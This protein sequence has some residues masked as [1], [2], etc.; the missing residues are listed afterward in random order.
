[1]GSPL[2]QIFIIFPFPSHSAVLVVLCGFFFNSPRLETPKK[3]GS[4]R[5][6]SYI[7]GGGVGIPK[8]YVKFWWPLFLALKPDLKFVKKFTRPNF[9]AK[10]F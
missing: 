5:N 2:T 3:I 8:L 4:S 10:E 7:R 1:M 9:R 6:I